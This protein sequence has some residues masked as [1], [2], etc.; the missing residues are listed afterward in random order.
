[1]L[2]TR[3]RRAEQTMGRNRKIGR[4]PAGRILD[5]LGLGGPK[6]AVAFALIGV[7][8]VMWVRVLTGH[9]P[10]TAVAA[11][12]PT[13]PAAAQPESPPKIRLLELPRVV[14]RH[15]FIYRDFFRM[16]E[17]AYFRP[18]GS[19]RTPGTD[20]EVRVVATNHAQE[21]VRRIASKLKLEAVLHWNVDPQVFL[22]DRLLKVGDR[23]TVK[24]ETDSVEFEV[25]RVYENSVLVG[26]GG[27]QLR[28][29]V[30]K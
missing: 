4:R 13:P 6:T 27:T 28:L 26:S 21:V 8:A 12:A 16:Q 18:N 22:N 1:M 30:L 5:R 14:G 29:E 25:L 23:L 10:G 17:R 24:D 2:P 20:P 19:A 3:R 11:D 9:K 7:M 15:D